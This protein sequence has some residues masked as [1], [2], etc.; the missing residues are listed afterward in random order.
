MSESHRRLLFAANA[1]IF[2]PGF[3]PT[4]LTVEARREL[5]PLNLKSGAGNFY[6]KPNGV[7]LIDDAG[8][9]II[10]TANY[11]GTSP[12]VRLATQSGP[13]LV[14]AGVVNAQFNPDSTSRQIRSGVG[15]QSPRQIVFV[16]SRQPF[17]FHEFATLFKDQLNCP[18]ALYLDG[19]ISQFDIPPLDPTAPPQDFA[20]MLA[21]TENDSSR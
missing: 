13:L 20:A 11:P 15:I 7:F 2:E 9:K 14:L 4:G 6:L 5:V 1:G 8:A 16:L 17:T 21:V 3:T 12:N 18:D 10:D 19:G